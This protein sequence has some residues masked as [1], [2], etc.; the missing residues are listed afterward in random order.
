M[1]AVLIPTEVSLPLV[2]LWIELGNCMD[3]NPGIHM[4]L[5]FL[6]LSVKNHVLILM[7]LTPSQ[8]QRVPSCLFPF[9]ICN[10]FLLIVR[11]LALIIYNIYA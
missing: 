1:L 11:N 10:F 7:P 5:L 4:E 6:Y 3:T 2:L 8:H 9:F